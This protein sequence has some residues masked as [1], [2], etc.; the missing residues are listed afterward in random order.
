MCS[1]NCATSFANR[2][3]AP[4]GHGASRGGRPLAQVAINW[5]RA[6]PGVLP[7]VG[8][9]SGAQSR[10]AMGA[11]DWSLTEAEIARLDEASARV[12]VSP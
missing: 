3:P 4:A 10:E 6:Q 1:R 9:K 8:V 5:L 7:I 2:D 12:A 11:R